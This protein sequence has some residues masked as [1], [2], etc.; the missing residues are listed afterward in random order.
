MSCVVH[1]N[2]MD[3]KISGVLLPP[4]RMNVASVT[5]RRG[6]RT[7]KFQGG[8]TPPP[9]QQFQCY[10][11]KL[12]LYFCLYR[13]RDHERGTKVDFLLTF[14]AQVSRMHPTHPPQRPTDRGKGSVCVI[15]HTDGGTRC[16]FCKLR[17]PD[18]GPR[19]LRKM[20]PCGAR[21]GDHLCQCPA[22]AVTPGAGA[23]DLT[24][25]AVRKGDPGGDCEGAPRRVLGIA[26][27]LRAS[28]Q[29]LRFF[30]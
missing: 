27:E 30:F 6:E 21:G 8:V 18:P 23:S 14:Y 16:M 17:G 3:L 10:V 28:M 29:S 24:Q 11:T 4:R 13:V 26:I 9:A 2:L 5:V 7:Q 25:P 1:C 19:A 22:T 20:A 12:R 15:V